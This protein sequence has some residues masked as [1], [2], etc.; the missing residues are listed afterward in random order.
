MRYIAVLLSA[1]ALAGCSATAY[2][3]GYGDSQLSPTVFKINAVANGAS[4]LGRGK[5]YS[6]AKSGRDRLLE[7]LQIL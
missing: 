3:D 6:H 4:E 7:R 2:K 1:L 5:R